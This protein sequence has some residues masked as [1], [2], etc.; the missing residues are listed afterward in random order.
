[1]KRIEDT[2]AGR[3]LSVYVILNRRGELVGKC[4]AHFADSGMVTV[5]LINFGDEATHRTAKAMGYT[6]GEDHR[7]IGGKHAGE[8]PYEVAGR[9]TGRAGGGGYD[10][11][12]A[13][14]SGMVFD[15]HKLTDHGREAGAPKPPKGRTTF[16]RDFKAPKGWSLANWVDGSALTHDGSRRW[17]NVPEG[18]SGFLSCFREAG[19]KY[20]EALGYRV[21][22]AL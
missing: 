18:E 5:E 4:L 9:Q 15:G 13:A 3:S 14:L 19:F 11:F 1:M 22:Q 7:I 8:Y 12:T 17:P 21:I 2:A 16:P 6:L 10:K 20:L